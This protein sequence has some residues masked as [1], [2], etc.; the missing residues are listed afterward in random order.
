MLIDAR[1]TGIEQVDIWKCCSTEAREIICYVLQFSK[2]L[3]LSSYINWVTEH[4]DI[5]ANL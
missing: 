1:C 4:Q 5:S 2:Q 3:K